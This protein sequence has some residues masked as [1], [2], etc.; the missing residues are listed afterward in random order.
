MQRFDRAPGGERIHMEDFAQ[1]FALFPDDKYD[2]RSYANIASVL[3]AETGQ[4]QPTNF[5]AARIFR[6]HRQCRHAP[7][8]LVAALS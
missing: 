5:P 6:A 4:E 7:Q 1:V 8:E 2:R 3:W